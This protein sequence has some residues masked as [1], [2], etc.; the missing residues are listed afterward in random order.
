MD[1]RHSPK[2]DY[3]IKANEYARNGK[4]LFDE[5]KFAE[6]LSLFRS[7]IANIKR[8][9]KAK[10]D[11]KR[12][13]ADLLT[14][15]DNVILCLES[16]KLAPQELEQKKFR[17]YLD[18]LETAKAYSPLSKTLREQYANIAKF[19]QQAA[20][21]FVPNMQTP[22]QEH[23]LLNAI[24][25]YEK[26]MDVCSN[27]KFSCQYQLEI[28]NCYREAG[29]INHAL[30]LLNDVFA[31]KDNMFITPRPFVTPELE[32]S[33]FRL[34]LNCYLDKWQLYEYESGHKREC[35][36]L[37][38]FSAH[39]LKTTKAEDNENIAKAYYYF[40]LEHA[41]QKKLGWLLRAKAKI[42]L[43]SH[44]T[45][46]QLYLAAKIYF[47]LGHYY[48]A[49]D[50]LIAHP[51]LA[52]AMHYLS[53]RREKAG[54]DLYMLIYICDA[55]KNLYADDTPANYVFQSIARLFKCNNVKPKDI[56]FNMN[57]TK[58]LSN[59]YQKKACNPILEAML[60]I[61][62]CYW[63]GFLPDSSFTNYLKTN[64]KF[65]HFQKNI[66]AHQNKRYIEKSLKQLSMQIRTLRDE[67]KLLR[68]TQ[69]FFS[70]INQPTQPTP[71]NKA[72]RRHTWGP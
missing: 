9:I 42:K 41:D 7:A 52:K 38:A 57:V 50:Q 33:Y 51:Y 60:I 31:L 64:N 1:A 29:H 55:L 43:I 21:H 25:C 11:A 58:L 66:K 39:A 30:K 34:A 27:K 61:K 13:Y 67:N 44:K 12:E 72:F 68:N 69:C 36:R 24:A 18:A 19:Y 54:S 59:N 40:S 14:F 10:N 49:S 70:E 23:F 5:K 37:A 35:A 45:D 65:E 47:A 26:A 53:Q 3:R 32:T 63:L 17:L 62:S 2:L 46:N 8:V 6:A 16:M 48:L 4:K 15:Y 22:A 56:F 71:S 28:A 20:L